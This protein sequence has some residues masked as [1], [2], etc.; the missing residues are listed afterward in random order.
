[1]GTEWLEALHDQRIGFK[2]VRS[3][4]SL[5]NSPLNDNM[6]APST[7]SRDVVS[8][9]SYLAH[10][11][12]WDTEKPYIADFPLDGIEGA[13]WTNQI[14][15]KHPTT[16]RDVRGIDREFTL[17]RN[18]FCFMRGSTSLTAE[19]AL[20]DS[21]SCEESYFEEIESL[22]QDRFPMYSRFECFD[23]TVSFCKPVL[24]CS[25]D[26][27]S[28]VRKRDPTFPWEDEIKLIK[29]EQPA[30]V[31]HSDYSPQG[32]LMELKAVFPGQEIFFEDKEFD[33][34][35]FVADTHVLGI[36]EQC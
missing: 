3:G 11:K 34:L 13:T 10:D 30:V 5:G 9:I 15:H 6:F 17:D 14:L 21:K 8:T 12:L 26:K 1:M 36:V 23:L 22:M 27:K 18:G 25:I 35:K 28:Q 7:S 2:A 16:I 24:A 33:I 32:A 29:H 31:A 19:A 20:Q 4:G